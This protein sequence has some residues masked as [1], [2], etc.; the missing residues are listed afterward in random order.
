MHDCVCVPCPTPWMSGSQ[1]DG[2]CVSS[3]SCLECTHSKIPKIQMSEWIRQ[4]GDGFKWHLLLII[5]KKKV[6]HT[7]LVQGAL[8]EFGLNVKWAAVFLCYGGT[9]Q[10]LGNFHF[11][12]R[13]NKGLRSI[14]FRK[15][16]LFPEVK[17][18]SLRFKPR[19]LIVF[20]EKALIK[21]FVLNYVLNSTPFHCHL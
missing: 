19:W 17:T 8:W 2:S 15:G 18:S 4:T 14:F 11:R 9:E 20:L 21:G 7:T 12:K 16:N 10:R 13:K 3:S 5:K 1:E 6:T